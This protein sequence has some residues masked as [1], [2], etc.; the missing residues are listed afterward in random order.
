MGQAALIRFYMLHVAFLPG[1]TLGLVVLHV[2]RVRKDGGLARE[3]DG[4]EN[5]STVPAWPQLL[6][7]EAIL[8]IVLLTVL[9]LTATFVS[10]P[11]GGAPDIHNPSNPEKTP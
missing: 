4:P 3:P 1:L 6:L 8:V 5:V 7:R 2:W 10:A 9:C 11:L